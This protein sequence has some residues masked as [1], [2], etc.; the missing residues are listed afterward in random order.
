M[1]FFPFAM[2]ALASA[3]VACA[4]A[5]G[6][7][8]LQQ[9]LRLSLQHNPQLAG[10]QFRRAAIEGEQITASL[11]PETRLHV[12]AENLAGSGDYAGTKAIELTLSFSSVLEL[13]GQRD[14]RL[15]VTTTRQQ[16]LASEKRV[17]LLDLVA[18][19]NYQF[20]VLLAAQE[21][22]R[23]EEEARQLAQ[24]LVDSLVKRVQAGSTP[25]AELLRARAALARTHIAVE[26][27]REQVHQAALQLSAYWADSDPDFASAQGDLFALANAGSL[28]NW[29]AQLAH[30][31]DLTLLADETRLRAAELRRAEAE[32]R[33]ALGWSAGVRHLQE[34]QD[35]ALVVGLSVPLASGKRAGGAIQTARAGQDAARSTEDSAKSRLEIRLAQAFSA[36][37]QA[38]GEAQQLRDDILPLLHEANRA[39][40]SA[41]EQGRYSSLELAVAQR[42]LL[43]ARADLISVALRA[44]ETRI[45]LERLTASAQTIATEVNP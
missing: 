31:P 34:R 10:Y 44:H 6:D 29:Q 26:K 17:A 37:Q 8:S 3:Y 33:L 13:G 35:T 39:T 19:V 21:R 20:I 16:Q 11:R 42:E 36:H 12:E 5:Q 43:D 25:Q 45:E 40:T 14:S 32:G 4:S 41:F 23:L 30:N 38:W 1:K 24:R 9:A 27:A 7:I 2:A 15:A 28:A 18:A 22:A